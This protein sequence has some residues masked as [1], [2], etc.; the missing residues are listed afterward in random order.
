MAGVI[1]DTGHGAGYPM[2]VKLRDGSVKIMSDESVLKYWR[3]SYG[4]LGLILGV[5]MDLEERVK[6][7]LYT[8]TRH[9]EW[10]EDNYWRK[11]SPLASPSVLPAAIMESVECLRYQCALDE[12]DVNSPIVVIPNCI[13]SRM[14]CL[15]ASDVSA[16]GCLNECD[17]LVRLLR[18]PRDCSRRM[19]A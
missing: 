9:M 19:A 7:Q 2:R 15:T 13:N 10:S 6:Y 17:E 16:V 18:R 3:N 12:T 11:V 8:K 5:E 14:N 1:T 4:L